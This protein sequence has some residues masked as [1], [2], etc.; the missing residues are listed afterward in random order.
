MNVYSVSWNSSLIFTVCDVLHY[1]FTEDL[2]EAVSELTHF[3]QLTYCLCAVADEHAPEL[4][5]RPTY[6]SAFGHMTDQASK[7]GMGNNQSIIAF[8]DNIQV[9]NTENEFVCLF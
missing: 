7:I 8:Y 1:L 5:L 9:V 2:T 6:L 3:V 4:S